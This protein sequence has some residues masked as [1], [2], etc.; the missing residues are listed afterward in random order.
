MQTETRTA[1]MS[2]PLSSG[3]PSLLAP[4]LPSEA[5]PPETLPSDSVPSEIPLSTSQEAVENTTSGIQTIP[6]GN[7]TSDGLTCAGQADPDLQELSQK[8]NALDQWQQI[9]ESMAGKRP[10]VFLDYD[11]TLSPIVKEPDRAFMKDTMRPVLQ[12]VASMFTTA[13]VTGRSREKVYQ[14]VQLDDVY[15]AGSHGFDISGPLK[16]PISCQVADGF[17]PLL[18]RAVE[19][20]EETIAKRIQGAEIEDNKF[21]LSVHY[22]NVSPELIP[23]V[24][25][26]VNAYIADESSLEL[27]HGKMVLEV[28][29][30]VSWNKGSAV[31]WILKALGLDQSEDVFPLY[32]GDDMTD[33]DA[34]LALRSMNNSGIGI[35]VREQGD[36]ERVAGTAAN[37]LL[38]NPDEVQEFLECLSQHEEAP[39]ASLPEPPAAAS[40]VVLPQPV[41]SE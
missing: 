22:R 41:S 29:P 25:A 10:V 27:R 35:L 1:A 24:H 15:Y 13:I 3:V 11:G 14:F 30:K 16:H 38:R 21:A 20:F 23:E 32:L 8:K 33:E 19:D 12:K 40:S 31:V 9:R 2:A 4:T 17:R 34:F 5:V 18:K 7:D 26:A 36:K 39:L 37:Y 6:G 28:R